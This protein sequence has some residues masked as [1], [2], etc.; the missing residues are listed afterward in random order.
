MIKAI[1]LDIEGTTTPIDFVHRTLF[2]FARR[3]M[4]RFVEANFSSLAGEIAS[5]KIEYKEDY[6]E[7]LYAEEFDAN[8]A[9]SISSYL[10][11]LIDRDRKSTA[12]KSIQ[13]KIWQTGYESGELRSTVFGDV[14]R[15][16]ERWQTAGKILAIYSSGSV[17][18]Q[19]LIF[20]HSNHGDLTGFITDYF[21]TKVGGKKHPASYE[22]IAATLDFP[23]AEI[24]FVSD[25]AAELDAA[26]TA[27]LQTVLAIR[28]GNAVLERETEHQTVTS[29]DEL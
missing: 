24:T 23:A 2:P 5:L 9:D 10:I 26:K 19:R 13:G 29:F 20:K 28:Q 15:A 16:F 6:A 8:A 21:D 7:K 17:L 1:L 18:A 25:I 12:L 14:P 3:R 4:A 11:F 27:G 22:K